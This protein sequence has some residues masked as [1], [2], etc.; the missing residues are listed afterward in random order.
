MAVER[1]DMYGKRKRPRGAW[2]ARTGVVA[3]LTLGAGSGC[4]QALVR[5]EGG[6]GLVSARPGADAALGLGGDPGVI[7]TGMW[8]AAL[9]GEK[10][11]ALTE[12]V[13]LDASNE[14]AVKVATSTGL[15]ANRDEYQPER[16]YAATVWNGWKV[17]AVKPESA[18]RALATKPREVTS[19]DSKSPNRGVGS[20]ASGASSASDAL[21]AASREAKIALPRTLKPGTSDG[22]ERLLA[23][24]RDTKIAPPLRRQSVQGAPLDPEGASDEVLEAARQTKIAPPLR[25]NALA[26]APPPPE[27]PS[28]EAA[29]ESATSPVEIK[30]VEVKATEPEAA[31]DA[32]AIEGP[33][34][35]EATPAEEAIAA[36][37]DDQ[38][39]PE[40]VAD[41]GSKEEL[42]EPEPKPE[43][44]PEPA[45]TSRVAVTKSKDEL[46]VVEGPVSGGPPLGPD[47]EPET[48]LDPFAEV[49]PLELPPIAFDEPVASPDSVD[50]PIASGPPM[51]GMP[52]P[53]EAPAD[54]PAAP[55]VVAEETKEEPVAV[56]EAEAIPS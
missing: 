20:S 9:L 36:P 34:T 1:R 54:E 49:K 21:L 52:T 12:P 16:F 41:S 5:P 13:G 40:I 29:P 35:V 45:E 7:R 24:S 56:T 39:K 17:P 11:T 22:D 28:Q 42:P 48:P 44:K 4:T 15:Y 38:A 23:A 31:P 55:V 3:L 53:L 19:T 14:T 6:P 47:P 8:T 46:T 10:G 18:P 2:R 32:S 43:P 50:S 30:T 27:V 33:A 25:R 26:A 51:D 37:P